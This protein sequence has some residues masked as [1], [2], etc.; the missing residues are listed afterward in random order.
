MIEVYKILI[1]HYDKKVADDI[2]EVCSN[3]I[4][5]LKMHQQATSSMFGFL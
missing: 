3:K 4:G 1:G 5:F 2:F